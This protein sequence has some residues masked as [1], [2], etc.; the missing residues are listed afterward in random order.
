M[1]HNEKFGMWKRKYIETWEY[2]NVL[3]Y[4]HTQPL[5]WGGVIYLKTAVFTFR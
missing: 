3:T 2:T 4:Q 1:A 5:L